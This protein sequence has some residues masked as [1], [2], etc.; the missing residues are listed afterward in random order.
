M[1]ER[2]V[3]VVFVDLVGFDGEGRTFV[4]IV[5]LKRGVGLELDRIERID[6]ERGF[7]VVIVVDRREMI[8]DSAGI[9]F[10]D[11]EDMI[12]DTDPVDLEG[13][14]VDPIFVSGIDT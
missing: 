4:L 5:G 14:A 1:V 12:E 9:D 7:V 11:F 6:E 8:D 2:V 10:V 13:G 3:D